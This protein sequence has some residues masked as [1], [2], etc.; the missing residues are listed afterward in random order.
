MTE[1][2]GFMT[3]LEGA[4]DQAAAQNPNPGSVVL[5]R[6]NRREYRNSIHELLDLDIDAEDLLPR[7]DMSGGFDNVAEVLKITLR[8]SSSICPLRAR[9]ASRP[10]AIHVRAS[11]ARCIRAASRPS[12]T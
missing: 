12:S 8:S 2:R 4:L 10:S 9:S 6:L 5:H 3:A 1:R 11:P 7:D